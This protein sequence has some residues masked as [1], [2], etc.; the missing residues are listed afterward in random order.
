MEGYTYHLSVGVA[1]PV[2]DHCSWRG[3]PIWGRNSSGT[4][5]YSI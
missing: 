2:E 4:R 3:G 5:S 1:R